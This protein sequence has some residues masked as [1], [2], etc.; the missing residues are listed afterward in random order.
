M[1]TISKFYIGF[2]GIRTHDILTLIGRLVKSQTL[3]LAER[4]THRS[5]FELSVY[6]NQTNNARYIPV[7]FPYIIIFVSQILLVMLQ[8][9]KY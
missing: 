8:D 2:G 9:N 6:L 5:G 7:K 1:L 4:R 3:C